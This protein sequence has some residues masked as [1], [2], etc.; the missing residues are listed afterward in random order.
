MQSISVF[1]ND[2]S[3]DGSA[4]RAE[5]YRVAC[6]ELRTG[7][8]SRAAA[9]QSAM[10]IT[11]RATSELAWLEAGEEI[12]DVHAALD[13]PLHRIHASFAD[14]PTA[15]PDDYEAF[16]AR[17]EA[18]PAALASLRAGFT[19]ALDTG[20]G[21]AL[22]QVEATADACE[23]WAGTV[24]NS[25]FH[26]MRPSPSAGRALERMFTAAADAAARAYSEMGRCLR[27]E[28]APRARADDSMGPERFARWSGRYAGADIGTEDYDWALDQIRDVL[29]V[30]NRLIET[31]AATKPVVIRG[32]DYPGWASDLLAGA[33][34]RLVADGVLNDNLGPYEVRCLQDSGNTAYYSPP[35]DDGS[36]PAVIWIDGG[37]SDRNVEDE[38]TLL[39]HEGVPGHHVEATAQ[40]RASH[41]TSY[42][43]HVYVIGHSEGWGLYAERLADE[44]G[45]LDTP[46]ARIAYLGSRSLQLVSLLIDVG[47]HNHLPMPGGLGPEAGPRWTYDTGVGA[48]AALGLDAATARWWVTNLLGRPG[49]RSCYAVGERTWCAAVANGSSQ[50]MPLADVHDALLALGPLGLEQ[51]GRATV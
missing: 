1:W 43:R 13:G 47:V 30:R 26:R 6:H 5:V 23:R 31:L 16:V 24:D 44:H 10:F 50:G 37:G 20:L 3:P 38:M 8:V 35:A 28:Y 18:V 9:E 11:E 15:T 51:L 19:A 17:L 36:R 4:A 2:F 21:S 25:T 22:R 14:L 48:V 45:L 49:H 46:R 40:R 41:L 27:V 29:R 32:R 42:Q 39:F 34:H 12:G 7:V 33:T